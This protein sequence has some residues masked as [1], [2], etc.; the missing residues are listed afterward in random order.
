MIVINNGV[1]KSGTTLILQYQI[2]MI[3]LASPENGLAELGRQYKNLFFP[4]IKNKEIES[5]LNI[6]KK[7][8]DFVIK[9]HSQPSHNNLKKLVEEFGA[10]VT[11]GYRDPRDII[12]SAMDHRLRSQN[13]LDISGAFLNIATIE[14]GIKAVKKWLNIYYGWAE[15][16]QALMIKYE[17]LIANKF[18]TLI[19]IANF[20]KLNLDDEVLKELCDKHERNKVSSWNF[21]KGTSYRWQS[22]MSVEQIE[23]CNEM[24]HDDLIKLGYSNPIKTK[25]TKSI[26]ENI[27]S[28]SL[29]SA[30]NNQGTPDWLLNFT[31]VESTATCQIFLAA[32]NSYAL[33]ETDKLKQLLKNN[34]QLRQ[35]IQHCL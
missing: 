35:Y 5:F 33:L 27:N 4:Y 20:L 18:S 12:L 13:K 34:P 10:K 23:M 9:V 11:C 29:I 24:L 28:S 26:P 6:E 15:Y 16:G 2:D 31:S 22:E 19:D 8:G 21:N 3:K 25:N 14:D 1:P 7:C 32:F 30:Q 17:D